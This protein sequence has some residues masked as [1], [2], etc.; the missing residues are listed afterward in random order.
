MQLEFH[1]VR[2]SFPAPG[3]DRAWRLALARAR[4]HGLA[5]VALCLPG[6]KPERLTIADGWIYVAAEMGGLLAIPE[7]ALP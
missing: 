4:R 2:G 1:G 7:S 3:A 5:G 6:R